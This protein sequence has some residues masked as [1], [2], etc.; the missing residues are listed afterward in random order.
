MS[1]NLSIAESKANE[2]VLRKL[3]GAPQESLNNISK[4][5]AKAALDISNT[6]KRSVQKGVRT[7][8]KYK[9]RTIIHQASAPGEPPK[10]DTGNLVSHIISRS[11]ELRAV[12]GS[13]TKYAPWLEFGTKYIEPRPFFKPAVDEIETDFLDNIAEAI[14]EAIEA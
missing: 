14:K 9:R 10:T 4:V 6:A 11:E 2:K 5:V 7:G 13:T 8:T 1:I 3:A 12:S